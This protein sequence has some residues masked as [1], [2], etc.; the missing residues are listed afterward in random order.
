MSDLKF[1][2]RYALLDEATYER[3]MKKRS[4]TDS[5]LTNFGPI[6]EISK[7]ARALRENMSDPFKD[8]TQKAIAHTQ[9]MR[10]Y[11]RDLETI[12]YGDRKKTVA[13]REKT[14]PY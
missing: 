7:T 8:E 6:T 9:L 1:N 12:R 14:P 3:L 4:P 11:L 5:S 13:R 2:R 10:T